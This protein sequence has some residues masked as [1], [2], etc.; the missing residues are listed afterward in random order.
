K[1]PRTTDWIH[2]LLAQVLGQR[3]GLGVDRCGGLDCELKEPQNVGEE[4]VG[5]SLAV[6][7]RALVVEG[8][9][10]DCGLAHLR[11]E[12]LV[13]ERRLARATRRDDLDHVGRRLR[14]GAV[15]K[16]QLR[17][18]PEQRRI[19]R[20]E[21]ADE[22]AVGGRTGLARPIA[23]LTASSNRSRAVS[24]SFPTRSTKMMW[25]IMSGIR[26]ARCAPELSSALRQ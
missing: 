15:E 18:A 21:F 10:E 24:S 14:P 23:G 17:V 3:L 13:H 26:T 20:G 12:P 19:D 25:L 6:F 9:T 4:R 2:T 22:C 11:S 5:G 7:R 16:R 1:Y 8:P